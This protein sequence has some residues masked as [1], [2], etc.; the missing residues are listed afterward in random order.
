MLI[1]E[2]AWRTR[3]TKAGNFSFTAT[4]TPAADGASLREDCET[5]LADGSRAPA[6]LIYERV[7]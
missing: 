6:I 3:G 1:N 4:L 2:R 5:T 7:S